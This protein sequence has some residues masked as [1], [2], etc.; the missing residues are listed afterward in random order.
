MAKV[1]GHSPMNLTV[2]IELNEQE[3]GALDALFGY[4]AQSFL[5]AFYRLMGQA[6]LKPYERGFRSLHESRGMLSTYLDR[7]RDAR[8]VFSGEMIAQP[9]QK[10][11]P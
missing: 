9:V 5:D 4:D 7:V 11:Q 3:A 1:I 2:T 10:V 6:Y 8:K